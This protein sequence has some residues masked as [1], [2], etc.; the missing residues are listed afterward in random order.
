MGRLSCGG[1]V[2]GLED[3]PT[4]FAALKRK[5]WKR[6][7]GLPRPTLDLAWVALTDIMDPAARWSTCPPPPPPLLMTPHIGGSNLESRPAVSLW[8]VVTLQP[9]SEGMSN[10]LTRIWGV[11]EP[12]HR[13]MRQWMR[14]PCSTGIVTYC[15]GM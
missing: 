3:L 15:A 10:S 1:Q 4:K 7:S 14:L 5:K 8:T 9:T 11:T 6:S 13:R 12:V 2:E